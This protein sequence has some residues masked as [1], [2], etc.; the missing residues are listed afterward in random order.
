MLTFDRKKYREIVADYF[1]ADPAIFWRDFLLAYAVFIGSVVALFMLEPLWQRAAAFVVAAFMAYRCASYVHEIVHLPK[2]RFGAFIKGW[3]IMIGIPFLMPSV[4]YESHMD[5]HLP[6]KYAT[7]EDPE[8]LPLAGSGA[9][10]VIWF[11]LHHAV[12]TPFVLYIRMLVG[13][14]VRLVSAKGADYLDRRF[15][16]LVINWQYDR[17]NKTKKSL[18][19]ALEAYVLVSAIVGTVLVNQGFLNPLDIALMVS[20]IMLSLVFNAVRT[21][22]AHRYEN[23]DLQAVGAKE[24]LLDSLNY[25]GP[26]WIGAFMAPV[27][28]RFHAL[29]HLF[30]TIPYYQLEGAHN[31][32]MANLDADDAYRQTA[33]NSYLGQMFGLMRKS[34]T[35]VQQPAE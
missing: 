16:S 33:F 17:R 26:A 31:A 19:M 20:V 14:P 13:L 21:L 24:Q 18:L 7:M 15:S 10:P 9:W 1:D 35:A 32:L 8:Y 28:L 34:N 2:S 29:H 23:H 22:G 5:H 3:N 12:V 25:T 11:V 30:P 27:G 4:M 6:R